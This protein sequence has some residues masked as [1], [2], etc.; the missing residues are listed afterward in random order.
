MISQVLKAINISFSKKLKLNYL[1]VFLF[2]IFSGIL[3]VLSIALIIPFTML[4]FQKDEL[5]K[6]ETVTLIY[7]FFNFSTQESFVIIFSIFF[8]D[9]FNCF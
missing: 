5:F 3:E 1:F 4:L 8:F 7:N 2:N 6:N 9:Y